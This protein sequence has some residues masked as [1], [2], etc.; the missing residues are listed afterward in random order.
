MTPNAGFDIVLANPT[1][2]A[3]WRSSTPKIELSYNGS[4]SLKWHTWY[5][6]YPCLFLCPRLCRYSALSG[7]LSFIT[8]NKFMR[9]K[10]GSPYH[11]NTCPSSL[12]IQRVNRLRGFAPVFEANGKAIAAYPAVLVGSRSDDACRTCLEGG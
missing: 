2:R 8:S 10:Y 5:G 7:W 6:G 1:L 9:A 3:S 4:L 11:E 12:R